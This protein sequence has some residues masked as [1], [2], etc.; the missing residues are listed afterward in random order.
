MV[1]EAQ[2]HFITVDEMKAQ[3]LALLQQH[4]GYLQ[5]AS[6]YYQELF[7]KCGFSVPNFRSLTDLAKLPLT[8]KTDLAVRNREFLAVPEQQIVDICQTS[9]TTGEPVTIWQTDADLQR[10]ARNE[11]LAFTAAGISS[12]DRVLIGAALDR[13]FMAGL[14]YFLG[15]RQIG[16]TAI[17][18]GSGQPALVAELIRQQRPNV[19]VGVPSLLL[20]VA[21]Q[22]QGG[23]ES[24]AQLG[25]DKLICI[26]EPVRN[27]DLSLSPLGKALQ[28]CWSAQI[29]GTYA[30][31]E[32]ATAFADCPAGCGG[33]LLPELVVVEV[34]DDQGDP[35]VAGKAGEVVVT[36]LGVEGT[37]LLRYRT[38]DIARL[39]SD[40]CVCGRQT[41]RLG[42]ILG[43]R[44]Q[45]LKCRGTTLF[46][47]AVS[48][49]LQEIVAIQGHYL[50]VSSD[51]DLSDKLRVV[52]G[53]CDTS[54]SA[55]TVAELIAAKT[56]VKPEVIIVDPE[57]IKNK[58]IRPEMRKPLTF[59][60]YRRRAGE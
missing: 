19:L 57:E 37:P 39:H 34:I 2:N 26:G 27:D 9:G 44:T 31:T 14:A 18:A 8:S 45:M 23:G 43:R 25:V 20:M 4:L 1:A 55:A 41:P 6:P 35:V 22:F 38:G 48:R 5:K 53:S 3:Q 36:P 29:L 40:P 56:R 11:Q 51:F 33:H 47:A 12:S 46:P 13:V 21:R 17:R 42:P 30:S 52:V 16:A 28:E 15:L 60:D 54:L 10:L 59:F 24:P 32:M 58:T 49:V 50:E 7:R